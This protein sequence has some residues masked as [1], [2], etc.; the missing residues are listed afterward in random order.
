MNRRLFITFCDRHSCNAKSFE[1][2]IEYIQ[3]VKN[4]NFFGT[5]YSGVSVPD[6][7]LRKDLCSLNLVT[8]NGGWISESLKPICIRN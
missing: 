2:K 4:I 1:K 6:H 7:Y 5:G 8:I 3:D